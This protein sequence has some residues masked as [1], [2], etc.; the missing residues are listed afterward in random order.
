MPDP[1]AQKQR[2]ALA[3]R[4]AMETLGD[5][6]ELHRYETALIKA[7]PETVMAQLVAE[8][9]ERVVRLEE[10]RTR[11]SIRLAKA[12]KRLEELEAAPEKAKPRPGKKKPVAE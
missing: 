3:V 12:E 5:G 2:A 10:A 6:K 8:L 7:A 1:V 4:G 9:A 11:A